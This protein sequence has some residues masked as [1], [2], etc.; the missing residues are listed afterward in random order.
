MGAASWWLTHQKVTGGAPPARLAATAPI[1]ALAVSAAVFWLATPRVDAQDG[2][3]TAGTAP[4]LVW[5]TGK[6]GGGD[7]MVT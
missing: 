3:D 1:H 7:K 5:F 4:P 2:G 6:S